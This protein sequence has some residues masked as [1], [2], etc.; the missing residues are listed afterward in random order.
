MKTH[1]GHTSWVKTQKTRDIVPVP[2]MQLVRDVAERNGGL[3]PDVGAHA[4]YNQLLKD[5]AR[6]SASLKALC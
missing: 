4:K 6:L 3:L 5:A 1:P 2:V